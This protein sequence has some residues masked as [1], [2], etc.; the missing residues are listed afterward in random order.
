MFLAN[1][2]IQKSIR[3]HVIQT[4][5]MTQADIAKYFVTT[6]LKRNLKNAT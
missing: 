1:S 4:V 3:S 6:G 2:G 5:H